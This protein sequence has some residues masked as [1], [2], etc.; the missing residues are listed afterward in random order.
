MIDRRMLATTAVLLAILVL[1]GGPAVSE[2]HETSAKQPP[3][4][5]CFKIVCHE[6]G[7]AR[8]TC[9]D[10][11]AIAD[12][13]SLNPGTLNLYCSGKPVPITIKGE[14]D[15]RLDPGDDI[16][17][18]CE[19]SNPRSPV[20][21]F[22]LKPCAKGEKPLRYTKVQSKSG[23]TEKANDITDLVLP[24]RDA[25]ND[26]DVKRLGGVLG[27]ST[28]DIRPGADAIFSAAVLKN[29]L[30]P[31]KKTKA[32][33][34]LKLSRREE[35]ADIGVNWKAEV[36]AGGK[37][38]PINEKVDGLKWEISCEVPQS[39][40]K[41]GNGNAARLE[42][43][44]KN[45]SEYPR[46]MRDGFMAASLTVEDA[47]LF[48]KEKALA[49]G[50]QAIIVNRDRSEVPAIKACG[51][52]KKTV[53]VFAPGIAREVEGIEVVE[54]G[55]DYDA[56]FSA[57][58]TG[59]CVVVQEGAYIRPAIEPYEIESKHGEFPHHH[60]LKSGK[61]E[62]DYL[63]IAPREF[64]EAA[65]PLAEHRTKPRR[66][67]RKFK[68]MTIDAQEIYDQFGSGR[69]GP[70]PIKDFLTYTRKHW[71]RVPRYVLLCADA[72]RDIDFVNTG[73][74]IPAYQ[75]ETYRTGPAGTDNWYAT[76]NKYGVPEIAI[77]RLPADNAG[78]LKQMVSK[79]IEYETAS[80]SGPWRRRISVFAGTGGYGPEIDA[81]LES[82]FRFIFS[83][84]LPRVFDIEITYAGKKSDYY[85]PAERFN[86]RFV[87]RINDGSLLLAYVGHGVV[88]G[89]D[90]IYA[91]NKA[92]PIFDESNVP[93]LSCKGHRPI[94]FFISCST[95]A[96]DLADKDCLA[97][98]IAKAKGGPI[99]VIA[100]S[101][102]S[103]QYANGIL[104][105]EMIPAFFGK[106][107]STGA[108]S[109]PARHTPGYALVRLKKQ[110]ITERRLLRIMLD[111]ASEQWIPS[112]EAARRLQVDHQY[113]Y[114]LIGDPALQTALPEYDVTL[115]LSK[116]SAKAGETVTVSG[117]CKNIE[118]GTA[119]I[120]LEC[121]LPAAL[122]PPFD[123]KDGS[124]D[125]LA[126]RH[127]RT[128][129][130]IV[131]TMET[132]VKD[133]KFSLELVPPNTVEKAKSALKPGT[134]YIKAYIV[135]EKGSAFGAVKIE[136]EP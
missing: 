79:I 84:M 101:R 5:K 6:R 39:L 95:G 41:E 116:T 59:L 133:G 102:E 12:I 105:I 26:P 134:Y 122:Y 121:D 38:L 33:L 52:S 113:L 35:G 112:K 19:Q 45:A 22:W 115:S 83:G 78:E 63:I 129:E 120:T 43:S 108:L 106:K 50:G 32:K 125:E 16:T 75:Y 67:G 110:N 123:V 25:V 54:S 7:M 89:L 20:D 3:P 65:K 14:A 64:L 127:R 27:V 49:L 47:A 117:A 2:N 60:D 46:K 55:E 62:A 37:K 23:K 61:N 4:A 96:F 28:R 8:I 81:L 74:T 58:E 100:S 44:L 132:E 118:K 114:N 42:I 68:V 109:I 51:F 70:Q 97:E 21:V 126:E 72:N 56:I 11:A 36:A 85:Y 18:Y 30:P 130:K 9:E 15:G 31:G 77:G 80:D 107:A 86:R 48:I 98:N 135:S 103:H 128:N 104:G 73:N 71:K 92:Y 124:I 24:L 93:E 13:S 17:F 69:F 40:F 87:E 66:D 94:V 136:I 57:Q 1:C 88:N 99:A 119:T 91:G 29:I 53:R 90:H 82:M 131:L 10:L 76:T 111:K 34:L